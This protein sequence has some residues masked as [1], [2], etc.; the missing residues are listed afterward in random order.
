MTNRFRLSV[1]ADARL[2]TFGVQFGNPRDKTT[3]LTFC[4]PARDARKAFAMISTYLSVSLVLV[5]AALA[6]SAATTCQT[7]PTVQLSLG[8]CTIL[9][10]NQTD[11]NSRGVKIG[12]VGGDMLC[13]VPST[14]V[15]STFLQSSEICGSDQLADNGY[16]MTPAQCR[17]RRGGFITVSDVASAAI[18]G[19]DTLNPGWISI[20]NVI[21]FAAQA[22]LQLL[23]KT[24]TVVEG[25]I[26]EGQMST[27]SHL[28]LAASST[29]LQAMKD[30]GLILARSWGLNAGSS[31]VLFP[32]DGSLVLGGFDQASLAGP[33]NEYAIAVPDILSDRH[34]P[35]QISVTGLTLN[36]KTP[37]QTVSETLVDNSNKLPACIEPYDNLFRMPQSVLKQFQQYFAQYTKYTGAP[38][39]PSKYQSSSLF[40]LEPGIVYPASAGD[41]NF[42]LR[43][44]INDDLTVEI[45]LYE[46]WRPLRGLD[47]NGNLVLDTGYNELQIYGSPA[48]EDAPVLGKAFLSQVISTLD[49]TLFFFLTVADS[50]KLYLFVDYEMM[51]FYLAPQ[52]LEASTPLPVSS[53]NCTAS[54]GSPLNDPVTKGLIAVGSVLGAL[55]IALLVLFVLFKRRRRAQQH[56]PTPPQ[57]AN[58]TEHTANTAEHELNGDLT[59]HRFGSDPPSPPIPATPS[60]RPGGHASTG[61][62]EIQPLTENAAGSSRAPTTGLTQISS[63][64]R[65]KRSSRQIID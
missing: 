38:V 16:T 28:G 48:P 2:R 7:P 44:T 12:V 26:T 36:I 39:D 55:V 60:P 22:P 18:D 33:F 17:S 64:S 6:S 30:A 50:M 57:T 14:V 25:L 61:T 62:H 8:N 46:L 35:L 58:T 15:N 65:A 59:H 19:L 32:R 63:P 47:A 37:N 52:N 53:A 10:P 13:V 56:A 4:T 3:C 5:R 41:F 34:C 20:G 31:S 42:T 11:V 43:F 40:N 24:V 49:L 29:L 1:R 54:P 45:P 51:K 27:T 9:A 21:K 23:T